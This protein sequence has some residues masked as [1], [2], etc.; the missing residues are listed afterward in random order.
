MIT[1]ET[2]VRASYIDRAAVANECISIP[3]G[4]RCSEINP[5]N[6]KLNRTAVVFI[7]EFPW[8]NISL[9]TGYPG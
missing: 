2:A 9:E 8:S 7:Q 3:H 5:L 4:F 6:A 1:V